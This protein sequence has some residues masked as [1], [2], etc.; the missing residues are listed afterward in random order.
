MVTK[1]KQINIRVSEKELLEL[2]KRAK[3]KELKRSDYIRSLL[4]ND[5]TESITKGIQ[6]YTVENLE[7]DKVYLKERLVETQKNFEGL[8]IEFKEVQ[9][10]AN[11]LT[12]DLNLEKENNTQ[13]MIELNTEK[14]KGFFA[15]LF[16]K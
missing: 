14:N 8:L 4:F 9:K 16:K 6:M 15:R 2:E 3:D 11:S 5:D 7:K 13:L 12:Q 1:E 10:K